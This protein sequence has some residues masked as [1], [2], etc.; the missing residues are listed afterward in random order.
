MSSIV[1]CDVVAAAADAAVVDVFALLRV[2][3]TGASASAFIS[4]CS[5]SF[6]LVLL[7]P[8]G[9]AFVDMDREVSMSMALSLG[10]PRMSSR[11]VGSKDAIEVCENARS[12]PDI[13]GLSANKLSGRGYILSITGSASCEGVCG[14]GL[15]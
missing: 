7:I 5:V 11:S 8:S 4:W 15:I 13:G 6:L 9:R 2:V 10:T 1:S 3:G 12:T 14:G